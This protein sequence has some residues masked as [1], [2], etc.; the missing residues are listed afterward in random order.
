MKAVRPI[1]SK[2]TISWVMVEMGNGR[3][4][5]AKGK[6]VMKITSAWPGAM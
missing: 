4:D 1:E 5:K 2:Q 6:I 3:S